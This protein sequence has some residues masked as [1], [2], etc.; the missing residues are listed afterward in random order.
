MTL[1]LFKFVNLKKNHSMAFH[2]KKPVSIPTVPETNC[3]NLLGYK[4][5]IRQKRRPY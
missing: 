3:A 4:I 5:K 2:E 1:F